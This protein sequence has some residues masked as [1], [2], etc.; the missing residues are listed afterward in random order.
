LREFDKENSSRRISEDLEATTSEQQQGTSA[1]NV[2]LLSPIN[3]KMD[4][5]EKRNE[6][7]AKKL[8]EIEQNIIQ[9]KIQF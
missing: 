1:R 4:E 6:E 9:D 2:I 8:K 7:I 3:E 5:L